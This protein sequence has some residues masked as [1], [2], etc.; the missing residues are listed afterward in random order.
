M[1]KSRSYGKKGS[2]EAAAV[3]VYFHMQDQIKQT[4]KEYCQ[5]NNLNLKLFHQKYKIY[6]KAIQENSNT[7]TTVVPLLKEE[8]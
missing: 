8:E 2:R 1:I 7:P 3:V 6:L 4:I 5:A